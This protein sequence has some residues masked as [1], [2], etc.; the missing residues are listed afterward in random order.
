[1]SYQ[2]EMDDH[3]ILVS[4][5]EFDHFGMLPDDRKAEF[6]DYLCTTRPKYLIDGS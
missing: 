2:I 1:M 4:R 6:F 5:Q 3:Y